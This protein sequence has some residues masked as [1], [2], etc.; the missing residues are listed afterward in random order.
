MLT[1]YAESGIMHRLGIRQT[2]MGARV[3]RLFPGDSSGDNSFLAEYANN[4]ETVACN[5]HNAMY[6]TRWLLDGCVNW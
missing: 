6:K 2:F 3:G 5:V 4:A 1:F